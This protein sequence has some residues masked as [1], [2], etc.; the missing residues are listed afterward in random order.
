MRNHQNH[1]ELDRDAPNQMGCLAPKLMGQSEELYS[2]FF[3]AETRT[4]LAWPQG[5]HLVQAMGAAPSGYAVEPVHTD[6]LEEFS[7]AGLERQGQ[8]LHVK[9]YMA[10]G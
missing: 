5:P 1:R 10:E 7:G 4:S 3:G 8:R 6:T 2:S 9:V